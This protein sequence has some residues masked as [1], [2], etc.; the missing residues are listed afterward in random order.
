M[1][2]AGNPQWKVV[3]HDQ[4]YYCR[5]EAQRQRFLSNPE[6]YVPA[7]AGDD[8]ALATEEQQSVPGKTAYVM[9]YRDRFY[10]FASR[11]TLERFRRDPQRDGG[12]AEVE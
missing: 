2:L 12:A 6:R 4:V 11:D 1:W 3:Y 10:L 5:S 8:P 9:L 7:Y